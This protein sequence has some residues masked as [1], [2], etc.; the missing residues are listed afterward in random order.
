MSRYRITRNKLLATTAV[1]GLAFVTLAMP[2]HSQP[3][4]VASGDNYTY[5]NGCPNGVPF[6][7]APHCGV[8][9]PANPVFNPVGDVDVAVWAFPGPF[10]DR[11]G[12]LIGATS[13]PG[14]PGPFTEGSFSLSGGATIDS[15]VLQI[16]YG[17]LSRGTLSITGPGSTL[18]AQ[19]SA[20]IGHHGAAYVSIEDGGRLEIGDDLS[21]TYFAY[22]EASEA[23]VN[24][25]GSNGSTSSTLSTS[26]HAYIGLDGKA[27]VNIT[28]GGALEAGNISIGEVWSRFRNLGYAEVNVSGVNS[29]N[30]ASAKITS[31]N[32]ITLGNGV[33]N[34]LDGGFAQANLLNIGQYYEG[35]DPGSD[36]NSYLYIDGV[37][38]VGNVRSTVIVNRLHIEGFNNNKM[39]VTN[40]GTVRTGSYR[41]GRGGLSL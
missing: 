34:I 13:L 28:D 21:D 30:Y 40:G 12:L 10:S 18:T 20:R 11:E 9:D 35:F 15:P 1:V 14:F 5:T 38:S 4:V 23:Y 27:V 3:R 33:V 7:F 17:D 26:G 8:P 25:S 31:N 39:L 29:N 22:D 6:D 2:A 24:I 37:S 36:S 41:I 16:A 32:G 19:Y